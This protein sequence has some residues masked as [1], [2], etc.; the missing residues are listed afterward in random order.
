MDA[1]TKS[2][3]D[4]TR[5]LG[6]P[7]MAQSVQGGAY[8]G[9]VFETGISAR[10]TGLP[11]GHSTATAAAI[12]S[13]KLPGAASGLSIAA[14]TAFKRIATKAFFR[15]EPVEHRGETFTVVRRGRAI[16]MIAPAHRTS[17]AEFREF[18]RAHPPDSEWE[19]DLLDLRRFVGPAPTT[20]SCGD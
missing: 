13:G 6:H 4:E 7:T 15:A 1:Q 17:L 19:H 5:L 3:R 11:G 8:W 14:R 2:V 12:A 18:L 10:L 16:A 9:V 20:D